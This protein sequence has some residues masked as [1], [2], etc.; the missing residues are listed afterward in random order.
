MEENMNYPTEQPTEPITTS[1]TPPV[2]GF[3]Q[4]APVMT[5][6]DWLI[7][8]LIMLIPVVNIIFLFIWAF[9]GSRSENPNKVSWAK[10]SLIWF[11]IV[12]VLYI[13]FFAIFGAAMMTSMAG[14]GASAY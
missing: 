8:Y 6:K 11:A 12:L 9:G 13:I 4:T 14:A 2:Y 5:V 7:I 3:S 10:A 1:P